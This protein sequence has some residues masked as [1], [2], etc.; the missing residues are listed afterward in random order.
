MKQLQTPFFRIKEKDL[1]YDIELLK[2]ALSRNWGNYIAAYS[3]KTNSL[4]WL[5]TY[6]KEQGFYAEV[7]SRTEYD[8]ALR[9]GFSSKQIIYNGPIKDKKVFETVLLAGGYI[10]LDSNYELQWMEELS[11][12]YP[13]RH[14]RIGL[15]V[16]CDL[17]SLCPQEA[18]SSKESFPS[19]GGRFGYC[20]E[21]GVLETAIHRLSSL[22]NVW[23]S[24]LHLH[25]STQSRSVQVFGALAKMA[26]KIAK[27]YELSLDY[28]DMGGGYFGGRDDMP[29]YRDYFR[30][31]CRELSAHFDPRKTILIAEPGVSLISRASTFETTVIDVK[32]IR[33]R[34]FVV[35]DG[36][37][38]NLNPL[39]T[40]HV[41]PH[42]MEY[43][44]DTSVRNS[45]PDQWICGA[46]CM[47]YDKLFEITDEVELLP[48]DKIIYDTAGGYTMCLNPLFINYFPAVYIER[49]DGSVFT[50]R[51][52]WTNEEFLQKNHWIEG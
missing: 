20:Y 22:S 25:S 28:V 24:G 46:T 35:T 11:T 12:L 38:T 30:E 6:L 17:A 16:N 21:N 34:K 13:N 50:A 4:P 3:V 32:D 39:V 36:S 27:E 33:G 52:P 26:A 14:F 45:V 47:E 2:E 5:L 19:E 49:E 37:R 41:Y 29:D 48:G 31:I 23:V 40:R 15:R 1:R 51:D 42:H 9:L 10:N 44:S 7:V 43:I 8:L 18:M